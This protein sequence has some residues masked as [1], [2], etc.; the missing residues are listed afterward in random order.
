[1]VSQIY[2]SELQRN[3]GYASDT[4]ATFVDLHFSISNDLISNT[5]YDKSDNFDCKISNFQL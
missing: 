5:I 1:M 3:K 2:P 4:E